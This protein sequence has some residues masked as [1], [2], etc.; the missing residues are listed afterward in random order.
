MIEREDN[1]VHLIPLDQ[2]T[3]LNPR[4]RGKF[5]FKQIVDN[6]ARLGLKKPITVARN[7]SALPQEEY[8]LVCGQGRLEAYRVLG[9]A[10][11]PAIIIQG[12][13]E[14]FLL[15][16]L[17]ENLA[18]RQHS[19][20]ELV[21]AISNLKERGYTYAQIARKTD[22]ATSYVQKINQLLTKGEE[23]LVRAVEK[24]QIPIT[25]AITIASSDD[26]AI[27]KALAD[28]YEKNDL[29]GK[30]LLTARRLIETRRIK[31][32]S[33]RGR[34]Q[35]NGAKISAG[36]VLQTYQRETLRQKQIIQKAR[37]CETR[38]L[39]ASSAIRQLLEDENFRTLLRAEALE[40]MP[41]YLAI[42]MEQPEENS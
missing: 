37:I 5:K 7:Q 39:F 21:N 15:M 17:A 32:K 24:G 41:Q 11:I 26:K 8:F 22:L 3:I 13:R 27:Q 14:D 29:R 42:Q 16:S 23:R 12:S 35:T 18:R 25:I 31:G 36:D 34:R 6:I 1:Q 4:L 38:L 19:P 20:V 33:L 9:E 40:T 10:E 30:Q 2:I 28:A